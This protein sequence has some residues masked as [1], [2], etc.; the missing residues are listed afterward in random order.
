MSK[1]S[2]KVKP[3]TIQEKNIEASKLVTRDKEILDKTGILFHLYFH[4][5]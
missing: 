4:R 2:A 1:A 5:P 3:K